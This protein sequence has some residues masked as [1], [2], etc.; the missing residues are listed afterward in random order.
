M[1]F[2]TDV[3]CSSKRSIYNSGDSISLPRAGSNV[4]HIS[5]HPSTWQGMSLDSGLNVLKEVNG[6]FTIADVHDCSSAFSCSLALTVSPWFSPSLLL[7]LILF[8]LALYLV[9]QQK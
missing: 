8:N 7:S 9:M 1:Y 2:E 6:N 5:V 4:L 3:N